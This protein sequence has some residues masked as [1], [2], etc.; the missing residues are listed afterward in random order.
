[1]DIDYRKFKE[2]NNHKLVKRFE[3]QATGLRGYI[4][5]HND[6]LGPAVGGTRMFPYFSEEEALKDVLR[7]SHAMSYKCALAGV[8]YG[9]GK[10][11]IIGNPRYKTPQLIK[12]YAAEVDKLDGKFTTGED[13]GI[14]ED[15][16]QLM[17]EVSSHFI[18][19]RGLAGDPSPFASLSTFYSAQVACDLFLGAKNLKGI[20]FAVKG[21]GK[22]GGELV[23]LLVEEGA[24]VTI[25]DINE[26]AIEE[27]K[28]NFPNVK[29]ADPTIIHTLPVDVYSPCAMGNEVTEATKEQIKAKII[30]GAANNQLSSPEMGDWLFE[31]G[32]LYIP[33]YV[34][35]AGG[36]IN[37]VDE[38]EPGGYNKERVDSRIANIKNTVA[39]IINASKENNK[40]TTRIADQAAED[41]LAGKHV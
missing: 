33:D 25:A 36:L 26:A 23:R 11:V 6:N 9:G 22:V 27:T 7:L 40:S 5:I 14:S 34:S 29:I 20:S 16:V 2:F 35:N 31:H 4:A 28:S 17:F 12:A 21:V 8:N 3:D 39:K 37:V 41:I 15:D 24:V 32:I 10:A 30:C 38:M 19:K 1:M 13:V 18:G